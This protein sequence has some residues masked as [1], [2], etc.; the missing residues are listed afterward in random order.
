MNPMP[1]FQY[2]VLDLG[3]I[4]YPFNNSRSELT[5]WEFAVT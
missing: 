1:R 2:I 5:E 3:H 4:L